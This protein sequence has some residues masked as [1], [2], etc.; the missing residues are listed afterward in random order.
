MGGRDAQHAQALDDGDGAGPDPCGPPPCGPPPSAPLPPAGGMAMGGP[1]PPSSAPSAPPLPLSATKEF[2]GFA[3]QPV[4]GFPA[5]REQVDWEKYVV[6][7]FY[8]LSLFAILSK[9]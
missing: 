5:Q 8:S 3:A 9:R 2:H 7:P 1:P 4:F 6:C